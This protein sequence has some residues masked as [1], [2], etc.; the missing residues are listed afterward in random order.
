MICYS[1]F[2]RGF[3]HVHEER[4]I[5]LGQDLDL[6]HDLRR[7]LALTVHLLHAFQGISGATLSVSNLSQYRQ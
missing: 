2:D 3:H 5:V 7:Y 6:T 4:M 1:V